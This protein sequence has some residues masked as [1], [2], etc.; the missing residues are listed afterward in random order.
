M[1]GTKNGT[2]DFNLI[3][4]FPPTHNNRPN[5]LRPDIFDAFAELKPVRSV[6]LLIDIQTN[7]TEIHPLPRRQYAHGQHH[8]HL[9]EVE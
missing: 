5:G 6:N 1:Q 3:S 9:L 2:L 4:L 7:K 8:R